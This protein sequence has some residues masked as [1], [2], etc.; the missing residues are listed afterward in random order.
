MFQIP[1]KINFDENACDCRVVGGLGH[2]GIPQH[3]ALSWSAYCNGSDRRLGST[4]KSWNQFTMYSNS[5]SS[6]S[7]TDVSLETSTSDASSDA[8]SG[9][10]SSV[11]S[12]GTES[13][14][15][16]SPSQGESDSDWTFH[17]DASGIAKLH[18]NACTAELLKEFAPREPVVSVPSMLL[19]TAVQAVGSD[20]TQEEMRGDALLRSFGKVATDELHRQSPLSPS[21]LAERLEYR[22]YDSDESVSSAESLPGLARLEIQGRQIA[23][24]KSGRHGAVH[25]TWRGQL[26]IMGG[27]DGE[28][29]MSTS[30][31]YNPDKDVWSS[32]A[33]PPLLQP[34]DGGVCEHIDDVLYIFGGSD[35]QTQQG[36]SWLRA[37]EMLSL[38]AV[39]IPIGNA[40]HDRWCFA[41][42]PLCRRMNAGSCVMNGEL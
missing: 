31:V 1:C 38:S 6:E 7:D 23:D 12:T 17:N 5:S 2:L 30:E 40:R 39:N 14:S 37:G 10:S 19:K 22:Q 28:S 35:Q 9:C 41:K 34:R 4:S 24:M 13:D 20:T 3:D 32:D 42:P 15:A 25:F 33:L 26:Y 11:M 21:R 16:L 36:A 29:A 8:R 18:W 27:F